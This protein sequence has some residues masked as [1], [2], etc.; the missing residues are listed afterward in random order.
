[1]TLITPIC[2]ACYPLAEVEAAV[3]LAGR[4]L[5]KL[6]TPSSR[7]ATGALLRKF[8]DAGM[9]LSRT[10]ERPDRPGAAGRRVCSRSWGRR[11]GPRSL[12]LAEGGLSRMP[13]C[14]GSLRL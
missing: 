4:S 8:G 9:R 2:A 11:T 3:L 10:L 12:V 5:L 14:G 13:A 6:S 1:M 7:T